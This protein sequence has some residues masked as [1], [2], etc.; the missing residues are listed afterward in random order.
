MVIPIFQREYS[1][2]HEQVRILWEDLMKLYK[3]VHELG[4]DANH[5]LGPIVRVERENGSVDV[6]KI[7]LIDCQQRIITLMVLLACLRDADP[8]LT[9]KIEYGYFYNQEEEGDHYY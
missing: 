8:S 1:W 2:E 6:E 5:F 4:I 3:N 9:G 7:L